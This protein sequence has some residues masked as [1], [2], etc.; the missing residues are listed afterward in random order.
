LRNATS[1][2]ERIGEEDVRG[3]G[4]VHYRLTVECDG[5]NLECEGSAPVDVWIADD[6]IV[7]RIA[8]EDDEGNVTFEF[9]DFGADVVIEPPS[10]DEVVDE[11]ALS[12]GSSGVTLQP[13]GPCTDD[14]ARPISDAQARNAL[15]RHGFS[16]AVDT[17]GVLTN[18]IGGNGNDVLAREG[19]V[20]CTV[21]RTPPDGAPETV[22]RRRVEGADAE[23]VLENLD[24]TIFTDSPT[25]EE[26]IDRLEAAFEE[27]QRE[28]QP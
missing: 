18:T 24:C 5:A 2:T 13:S 3:E 20:F 17:C 11:D 14:R 9:F 21:Q 25:G 22:V 1:E 27:L 28:I 8:L 15:R 12:S 10:A 16:V 7:R 23:L 19:I 26:K 6:G 4:T